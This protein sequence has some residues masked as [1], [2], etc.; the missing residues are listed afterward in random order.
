MNRLTTFAITVTFIL[1][2]V[3]VTM[4]EHQPAEFKTGTRGNLQIS[5]SPINDHDRNKFQT[6]QRL[7]IAFE[8]TVDKILMGVF[9][10]HTENSNVEESHTSGASRSTADMNGATGH[11]P[12]F[13]DFF[14][15]HAN[16]NLRVGKQLHTLPAALGS[17]NLDTFGYSVAASAPITDIAG[18]TVAWVRA[19]DENI[20]QT[21]QSNLFYT[22]FP[23]T[24]EGF[25]INPFG[26]YGMKSSDF[27][28]MSDAESSEVWYAGINFSANLL[29]PFMITGDFNY[30]ESS[31]DGIKGGAARGWMAALAVEYNMELFTPILFAFYESGEYDNSFVS[32]N[33]GKVMPNQ[34]T[35]DMWGISS[36]GFNGSQ[37]RGDNR[38]GFSHLQLDAAGSAI[39]KWGLG[40]HVSDITFIDQLSH[41]LQVVYYQGASHKDNRDFYLFTAQNSAWEANFNTFYQMYENLAALLELGYMRVN[42]SYGDDGI[43]GEDSMDDDAW[44]AAAGVRFRF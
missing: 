17:H 42:L 21:G 22:L 20:D 10:L 30:G 5:V 4:A 26:A 37:Y 9:R 6:V 36:F 11:E 15:P 40:L 44:K 25:Q 8:L 18:V 19:A 33:A 31:K 3:G 38:S 23:L 32:D 12:A 29:D 7:R 28:G 27:A 43:A 24:F 1:G 35:G 13:V 16:L 14:I 39:G 34:G 2:T 41:V